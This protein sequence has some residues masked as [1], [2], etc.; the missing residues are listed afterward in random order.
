MF[1]KYG[2]IVCVIHRYSEYKGGWNMVWLENLDLQGEG[3]KHI[4]GVKHN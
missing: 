4:I 2:I 3:V 1:T